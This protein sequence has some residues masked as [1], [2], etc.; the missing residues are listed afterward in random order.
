MNLY[1]N[2]KQSGVMNLLLDTAEDLLSKA[3]LTQRENLEDLLD[4]VME[5]KSKVNGTKK[6]AKNGIMFETIEVPCLN[7]GDMLVI[8]AREDGRAIILE[9]KNKISN[10][11]G[12]FSFNLGLENSITLT[13]HIIKY[14]DAWGMEYTAED[15]SYSEEINVYADEVERSI[16]ISNGKISYICYT[17]DKND[18]HWTFLTPSKAKYFVEIMLGYIHSETKQST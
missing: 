14:L 17:G 12:H 13:N 15:K 2:K 1:L 8:K 10:V 16:S 5:I 11:N 9:S 6:I 18:D 4:T 7:S 3:D